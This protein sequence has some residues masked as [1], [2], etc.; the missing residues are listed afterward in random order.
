MA[1]VTVVRGDITRIRCDAIINAANSRLRRG[2]GVDGAVHRAAGPALQ[3]ELER[4]YPEGC[5]TGEAVLT[6]G[7]GLPATWVVHAV[8]PVWRG[9]GAGEPALL[10]S[11][12]RAAFRLAAAAGSRSV[13]AP[14]IST[15][16]YGYP[17][18]LAAPIA[19]REAESSPA[20]V[21]E[22][23]LVAFDQRVEAVV[24]EALAARG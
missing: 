6:S 24:R 14:L 9:G 23:T 3:E 21:A 5:P 20:P 17:V 18:G 8:G 22:V 19:V 4:C 11:A 13:A 15:G 1:A 10:A 12:Y 7:H 16:V 2:G